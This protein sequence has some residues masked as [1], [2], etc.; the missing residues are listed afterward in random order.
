[1]LASA[2]LGKFGGFGS[3]HLQEKIG[4]RNR[5]RGNPGALQANPDAPQGKQD[6]LS[7]YPSVAI[8]ERREKINRE[9]KC[10]K[11]L[12]FHL[13]NIAICAHCIKICHARI[14]YMKMACS[15]ES[16][17]QES[18]PNEDFWDH[19]R[20][21]NLKISGLAISRYPT[22]HSFHASWQRFDRF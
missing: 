18:G 16:T 5:C 20:I 17:H 8:A 22:G 3:S 7:T 11:S 6:T 1:L 15:Q 21:A 10:R 9:N 13:V 2:C 12:S 14:L 19:S 4:K